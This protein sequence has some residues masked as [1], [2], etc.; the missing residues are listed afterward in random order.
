MR[1]GLAILS[2]HDVSPAHGENV[3]RILDEIDRWGLP[4]PALLVVPNHH[5]RWPVEA[6]DDF[7]K[8]I[9]KARMRG[10]EVLLHGYEHLASG[11][12]ARPRGLVGKAKARF[13]T[14][15]EGEFLNIGIESAIRRLRRGREILARNLGVQ[16]SGFV[17]PAWLQNRNTATALAFEG[18]EFHEDHLFVRRVSSNKRFMAPAVTFSARSPA[19]TR[20]SVRFAKVMTRLAR[21]RWNLRLAI[22]PI[23]FNSVALKDAIRRFAEVAGKTR[24]WV[25][26]SQFLERV[27]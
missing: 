1:D 21:G 8:L 14:D 15:G 4:S 26:Y 13:L 9:R 7:Q 27:S 10:S 12:A 22:H 17:A 24:K 5:S 18:F 19:R 6:F 11:R 3:V 25:T 23:D 2:L 16:A 20:A